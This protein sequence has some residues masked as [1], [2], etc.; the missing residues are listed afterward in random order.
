MLVVRGVLVALACARMARGH[1]RFH[2]RARDVEILRALPD[3]DAQRRLAQVSAVRG[4]ADDGDHLLRVR[5]ADAC[6]RAR[7]A[8]RGAVE[9]LLDAVQEHPV[10][11]DRW[12]RMEPEDLRVGH[13]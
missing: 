10:V 13:V 2:R 12:P 1:A 3:N 7:G 8:A 9:A 4:A 11:D 6:V 5:L